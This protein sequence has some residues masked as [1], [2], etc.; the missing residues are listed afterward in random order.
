MK[1]MWGKY[2]LETIRK[3]NKEKSSKA[4]SMNIFNNHA[5]KKQVLCYYQFTKYLCVSLEINMFNTKFNIHKD[6]LNW[7]RDI[8]PKR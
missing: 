1:P 3:L 2:D 4:Y 6:K 8:I 7:A 5:M